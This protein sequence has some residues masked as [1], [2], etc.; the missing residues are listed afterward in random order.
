MEELGLVDA[1]VRQLL[2]QRWLQ[3]A[4][5]TA[6][7]AVFEAITQDA[8]VAFAREAMHLLSGGRIRTGHGATCP[9]RGGGAIEARAPALTITWARI[10]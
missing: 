9:R 5:I 7:Q 2:V 6:S 8:D 1:A 3:Q 10:C 4:G